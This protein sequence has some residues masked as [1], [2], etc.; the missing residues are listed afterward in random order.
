M[1]IHG[2]GDANKY[3]ILSFPH[4]IK[5]NAEL[6]L[7]NSSLT[8]FQNTVKKYRVFWPKIPGN[9]L[10]SVFFQLIVFLLL[11]G[12]FTSENLAPQCPCMLKPCYAVS[13]LYFDNFRIWPRIWAWNT[14][15]NRWNN[16]QSV[17][18]S[19]KILWAH[20]P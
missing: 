11:N 15:W 4:I 8:L 1:H 13:W 7:R 19:F 16:G 20:L 5:V 2:L 6:P 9:L 3:L 14:I 12:F 10:N 18:H 17:W